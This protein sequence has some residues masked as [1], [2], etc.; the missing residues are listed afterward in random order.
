MGV[1]VDRRLRDAAG[2]SRLLYVNDFNRFGR[3]YQVIAQADARS[4]RRRGHPAAQDAQRRTATM[5]PLGSLLTVDAAYGPDRVTRYNSY[6]AADIN[7]SAAPGLS[8]G[9]A[10]ATMERSPPRRCRPASATSGRS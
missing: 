7:G 10:I 3:T 1:A 9:Q 2:L 5:V 4:A 6:P 8:S